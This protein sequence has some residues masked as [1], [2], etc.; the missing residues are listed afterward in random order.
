MPVCGDVELI[1]DFDVVVHR[2]EKVRCCRVCSTVEVKRK[3]INSFA[4]IWIY[5]AVMGDRV[6]KCPVVV[7]GDLISEMVGLK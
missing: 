3:V 5:A 4:H 2:T 1:E 7:S 6:I